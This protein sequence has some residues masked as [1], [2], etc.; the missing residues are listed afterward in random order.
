MEVTFRR[1]GKRFMDLTLAA[2][3]AVVT[4]PL[5]IAVAGAI[6]FDSG[7]P[8][9]F[10]QD[11]VGKDG[12]VFKLLKFRSMVVGTPDVP[13]SNSQVLRVTRIGRL[14]RRLNLDELPQL[15]NVLRG[16]MSLVG[17][18]PALPSQV[19]LLELR[20]AGGAER[21]RP[22]LTGLAQVN[23]Y[24]GMSVEAKAQFDNQYAAEHTFIGDVRIFAQ[25]V[26]YL[27]SPPPAY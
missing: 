18:R 1:H 17:P 20:R 10:I 21:V 12:R 3:G 11:R 7:L 23:A 5:A 2:A 15:M 16:E 6:A 19:D 4:A 8:I 13:S 27:S 9:L 14:I 25:T 26:R 24:N 22:G